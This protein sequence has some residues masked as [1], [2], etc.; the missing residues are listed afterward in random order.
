[1]TLSITHHQTLLIMVTIMI[2]VIIHCLLGV[3][4]FWSI[5]K[6]GWWWLWRCHCCWRWWWWWCQ[7]CWWSFTVSSKFI[8]GPSWSIHQGRCRCEL[9]YETL[10]HQ[11][12]RPSNKCDYMK[13]HYDHMIWSNKHMIIINHKIHVTNEVSLCSHNMTYTS[14]T[15]IGLSTF[16]NSKHQTWLPSSFEWLEECISW[17]SSITMSDQ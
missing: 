12:P 6:V 4:P 13:Y 15:N 2:I 7:W 17:S 1:M 3:E 5:H 8:H 14:N 16:T 11:S 9:F 10:C